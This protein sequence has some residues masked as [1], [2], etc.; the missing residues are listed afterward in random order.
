[1]SPDKLL[2]NLVEIAAEC[3]RGEAY[4]IRELTGMG[5]FA[6]DEDKQVLRQKI[7]DILGVA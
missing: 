3:G 7:K 5:Y 6:S 2:H 1:M 4:E